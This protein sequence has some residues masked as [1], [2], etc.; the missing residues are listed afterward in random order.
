[1]RWRSSGCAA[2]A[3]AAPSPTGEALATIGQV[4]PGLMV[5]LAGRVEVTHVDKSGQ[6]V[7]IVDARARPIPGRARAI[8]RAAGTGGR[9][10]PGAGASSD[11][12]AGPAAR[13]DD[14]RGRARRA[15]H[16]RADHPPHRSVG[17]RLRRPDHRRPRRQWRRA[18]AAELSAPQ[19]SAAAIARPRH[20]PRSQGA[21]RA[22]PRRSRTIA[23]RALPERAAAAQS[24]RGRAGALHRAG[25]S[26]RSEPRL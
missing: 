26:D 1:M 5:I 10:R 16:A 23:D 19:R 2:S 3:S 11:H 7:T 15:D 25:R 20:R 13:L 18:A 14:R 4:S 21:D 17:D 9:D 22:L 24:D 12:S 8:G 6:R